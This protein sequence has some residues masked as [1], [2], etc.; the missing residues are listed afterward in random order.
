MDSSYEDGTTNIYDANGNV[1]GTTKDYITIAYDPTTITG[2]YLYPYSNI[3]ESE[4]G[5]TIDLPENYTAYKYKGLIFYDTKPYWAVLVYSD[6]MTYTIESKTAITEDLDS[7]V[8][9]ELFEVISYNKDL[10]T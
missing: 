6:R 10:I 8:N 1:I 3:P 5:V 2:N 4:D 7:I 9:K